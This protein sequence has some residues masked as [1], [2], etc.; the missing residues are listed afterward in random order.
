MENI[1]LINKIPV[2]INSSEEHNCKL[3]R[4]EK[5]SVSLKID[6]IENIKVEDGREKN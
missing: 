4:T 3:E 1:E 5:R 6:P 2:I